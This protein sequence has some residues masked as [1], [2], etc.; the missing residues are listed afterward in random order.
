MN[1]ARKYDILE[2]NAYELSNSR[3]ISE[4]IRDD[5]LGVRSTVKGLTNMNHE[6]NLSTYAEELVS[7]YAKYSTDSFVLLLSDLPE[8]E[9]DKLASLYM[10][11][12]HRE[13][14]EC[15]HGNDFS[16][17]N[18]FTCALLKM[19]QDNSLEN[20][21][22]FAEVTRKNIVI[23][24]QKSLQEVIDQACNDHLHNIHVEAG[25]YPFQDRNSGDISWGII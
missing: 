9:Q 12:T 22:N 19:L 16:I 6:R 15:V 3:S 18:N 4:M 10:E 25:C 20:R 2:K 8:Y 17:D 1:A 21:E 14:G 5:L 13:T 11:Y 23:Y 7:Q 24:Y